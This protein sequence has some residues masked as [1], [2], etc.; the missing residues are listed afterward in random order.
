MR[1]LLNSFAW[2]VLFV[3]W[4]RV[5]SIELRADQWQVGFAKVDATPIQPQRLSGYAGRNKPHTAVADPI[6]VR[7]MTLAPSQPD[8]ASESVKPLV[9]VS[10]ETIGVHQRL[11]KEIAH[12]VQSR[13]SIPRSHLV[14]S[15][16]H[17][18]SAP[19]LAGGLENIF[20][21]DLTDQEFLAANGYLEQLQ[22]AIQQAIDQALSN[23]IA[24]AKVDIGEGQA[25][26]AV[27][28]R[29]IQDGR[30]TGF[31]VQQGGQVDHRLFVLR[32]T[33]KDGSLLGAAYQYACHCTSLGPDF[34]QISGDWAGLSA[35]RLEELH[36]GAIFVPVIGCGADANP[37][38][39]DSYESAVQNGL[40]MV[41]SMQ[42]A[43][44]SNRWESLPTPT[45]IQFGNA[46][47]E[48]EH[49]TQQQ[50]NEATES[51]DVNRARWAERMRKTL[52]AMGRLPESVPLPVHV[53]KFGDVLSW[54]FL[55]G[56]VVVDYQF[57]IEK[58][59]PTQKTWVAAYCDD[60]PGYVASESQRSE[61]GYEV[62]YSMIY[63]L[64]PGR[65]KS[66][67]Q[68]TVVTRAREISQQTRGEDQP[69]DPQ[70]SLK[71]M[72]VPEGYKVELVAAEPLI[73]DPVNIAFGWDGR[74]WVVQMSDYPTGGQGG[75]SVQ[76]LSDSDDD[77]ILDQS[78]KFLG[79]LNFPSSAHPWR[80]GVLI[81]A[82]PDI[83]FAQ[84]TDGD[85]VADQQRV[86]ISGIAKANPQ[87]RA[88]GFEIG[89]DGRLHFGVGDGTRELISHVN[90]QTYHVGGNDV[91]WN[92][93]TGEI[94]VFVNGR[95]QFVPA[96]DAFGNWF[97]NEN[98][99]PMYQFVFET[100]QLGD[101]R[102]D[103]GNIHHLLTPPAT[104]PVFPR[105]RTVDRFN[106]LYT[107]DRY[108]SACGSIIVRVD[109]VQAP[110]EAADS[111]H[112]VALVCEPVH[113]LVARLQLRPDGCVF[114]ANRH[115][116]DMQYD[117]FA[118][119]D[120]WSRPVRAVNSPDGSIWIADMYRYV[121]EH[122]EWIPVA[123][124]ER[125]DV[126]AGEGMGR[127]YRVYHRDYRGHGNAD[128][129]RTISFVRNWSREDP[130]DLLTSPNGAIRDLVTQAILTDQ[131]ENVSQ[132]DLESRVRTL[133]NQPQHTEVTASI[134]GV[135]AGKGWLR[136]S[137][138]TNVLTSTEDPQ[139]A[140][141]ALKLAVA[142]FDKL[143]ESFKAAVEAVPVANLGPSVDLQWILASKKWS[144]LSLED[145]LVS[146][147]G[148]GEPDRW[149]TAL[150]TSAATPQIANTVVE[151]LLDKADRSD[152]T[153]NQLQ[154]QIGT[155]RRLLELLPRNESQ[156]LFEL[157]FLNTNEAPWN[158][159]NALLLVG[160]NGLLDPADPQADG[161]DPSAERDVS[162]RFRLWVK[163][164]AE[165]LLD[166]QAAEEQRRWMS[167]LI[168]NQAMDEAREK[169]AIDTLLTQG[170]SSAALACQRIKHVPAD[171]LAGLVLARWNQLSSQNR[172]IAASSLMNRAAWREALVG[173]LEGT[174]AT[175]KANELP[176]T[177]VQALISHPDR[178]LRSRAVAVFGQPSPRQPIVNDYLHKMPNPS[179]SGEIA[180]GEQLYRDHCAVCHSEQDGK[181]AVGP[182]LNN[183]QHW[184]N[185]QWV[186]ALL[187]PSQAVEE[188]FKQTIVQ[189]VDGEII[190][191]IVVDE[192]PDEL[193]IVT[194]DGARRMVDNEAIESRVASIVSL[195]PDGFEARIS[196]EQ[197]ADLIQFL[198]TR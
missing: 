7:V 188:K 193:R 50:L 93:D 42:Q 187:D 34:N 91:A 141:W 164:A 16:T 169:A 180:R 117:F 24:E 106:D 162:K 54:V 64:Q 170:D 29:V 161:T 155:V 72:H 196:P 138:L 61:G 48:P 4:N 20:R 127:I 35:S 18:H 11:T 134:L 57:A 55:G 195:M 123:W 159:G 97:G 30:W 181:P 41:D 120:P 167:V 85:G 109:A 47:L 28:R 99:F 173:A 26:F 113:N 102:I 66:G 62:D 194:S 86:L 84:D 71:T 178:D 32:V 45:N 21:E 77:G 143:E 119:S 81:V 118:S 49:P 168:G 139:L 104:P 46:G 22:A 65:W 114:S 177:V 70:S 88:S 176:P 68:S 126:R 17:S 186:V 12:Y 110:S 197:L 96:R 40:K 112:P 94:E 69:L 145:G 133:L 198:R 179:T 105:S 189:T 82:A 158:A 115:P 5:D 37:E 74:V 80:D 8:A 33:A 58:E 156:R 150:L 13:Y 174:T 151:L 131:I 125:I 135:L 87:H 38:P 60:V 76:V 27:Q 44:A 73:Q 2:F 63:Y 160:L 43:L 53:W 129:K 116:D 146:I 6:H 101:M 137:D 14:L 149:L 51:G 144:E 185:H 19:H 79:E 39:R 25:D 100:E 142:R 153:P 190:G 192:T 147:L 75:G 172:S 128:P 140:G 111:S 23:P 108:T 121:I 31:G 184:N 171:D 78:V 83:L 152:C 124:Q 107:R 89:L 148:R 166:P 98:S 95:T 157:R 36:P 182:P 52:S 92:P 122:P 3:A 56:E 59:L 191:G 130:I 67:T 163:K 90:G 132:T 1:S 10:V 175:I 154:D 9:L 165:L 136:Q 103:E 183:L 15:S